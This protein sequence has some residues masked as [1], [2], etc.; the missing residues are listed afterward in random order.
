M[1]FI[2]VV[3]VLAAAPVHVIAV[4]GPG[5]PGAL[6]QLSA[7]GG[8]TSIDASSLHEYLLRPMSMLGMQDFDA[9]TAAPVQGWP[10][11]LGEVW[12]QGL[13]HCRALSGAPPWKDTI[14]AAVACA[15]RLSVYLWQQYVAQQHAARVFEIDLEVNSKKNES[16]ARGIS[17]EPAAG[18]QL[19]A[20]ASGTAGE[21][22]KLTTRVVAELIEN[23]GLRKARTVIAELAPAT[24]ADPFSSSPKVSD[25]VVFKKTCAAMPAHLT[26][27]PAGVTAESIAARW[28]PAGATG[29][30]QPCTLAFSTHVEGGDSMLGAM[31]IVTAALSCGPNTVATEVAQTGLAKSTP[32]AVISERLTQALAA[33]FCR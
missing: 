31:T 25:P 27:T 22:E 8:V 33:K 29:P 19:V 14:G 15:N 10:P 32:V 30:A 6:R 17:W 21:A 28:A 12:T 4:H 26:V 13:A 16:S 1:I 20:A 2:P 18:D 23:K 7:I 24:A 11:A 9:F 3:M 5:A